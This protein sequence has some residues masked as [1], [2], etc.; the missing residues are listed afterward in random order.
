MSEADPRGASSNTPHEIINPPELSPPI[1]FS[2][3]VVSRPGRTIW[4]GGQPALRQ[5]GS[6]QGDTFAEQFDVAM[7]NIVQALR[8]ADA[9]PEHVVTMQLFVTDGDEYRASLKELGPVW[10]RHFGRHYPAM[11]MFEI[12]GLFDPEARLEIQA[13]AVVPD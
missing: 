11:A 13:I 2:H 5:D 10:R 9:G 1:G 12:C 4:L 7:G 3:A 6:V 8:A